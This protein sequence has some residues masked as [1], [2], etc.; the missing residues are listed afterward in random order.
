[1]NDYRDEMVRNLG[2]SLGAL[3]KR[4]ARRGLRLVA[5]EDDLRY[6]PY[7]LVDASTTGILASGLTMTDLEDEIDRL[8]R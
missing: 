2:P 1:M 4:A 3:R 8:A 5:R 7:M 6:G